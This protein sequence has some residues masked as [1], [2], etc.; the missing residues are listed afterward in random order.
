MAR[1]IRGLLSPAQVR[2]IV[3]RMRASSFADGK[4]T[5]GPLGQTLKDNDELTPGSPAHRELAQK[6]LGIL[7]EN[8]DYNV[9]AIPRRALPPIFARYGPGAFYGAHVDTALMGPFPSMRSDLSMT[10]FLSEPD[11][12]E[13]GALVLETPLGEQRF[14]LPPG[15]AILYPTHFVHRVERITRGER[16]AV[17]TWVESLVRDPAQREI[18]G[19]LVD[20]MDWAVGQDPAPEVVTK[21]EKT[22]LNL[23]R[24]WANT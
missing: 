18:I 20:L 14:K 24:M 7:K 11:S 19:D 6:V 5:A 16:L 15:D 8:E 4:R 23:L 2:E 10:I 1:I 22:R 9:A 13:D 21:L 12:Y 17:I 3:Q